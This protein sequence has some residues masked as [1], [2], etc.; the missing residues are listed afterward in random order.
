MLKKNNSI[1]SDKNCQETP[2][3]HIWPVMLAK[4]S[5]N[6]QSVTRPSN[7]KPEMKRSSSIQSMLRPA[8]LQ[9]K[10]KKNDQVKS[11]CSEKNFQKLK[12]LLCVQ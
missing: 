4:E 9:S 11:V 12:V 8:K 10:Y 1:C 6:M 7:I 5:N 2:N 3:V